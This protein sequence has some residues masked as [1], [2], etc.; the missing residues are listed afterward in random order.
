MF[1]HR[2]FVWFSFDFSVS[3]G[4]SH[5]FRNIFNTM[6]LCWISSYIFSSSSS[7]FS[8][9][10]SIV[11]SSQV[12]HSFSF[13]FVRSLSFS[14]SLSLSLYLFFCEDL[15]TFFF[16]LIQNDNNLLVK[17]LL[18]ILDQILFF[19]SVNWKSKWFFC[20]V[21]SSSLIIDMSIILFSILSVVWTESFILSFPIS[22][23][24]SLSIYMSLLF[25]CI[26]IFNDAFISHLKYNTVYDRSC[27]FF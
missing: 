22:F 16:F 27:D 19:S 11:N 14:L 5:S 10:Y 21:S 25:S 8:I 2:R 9:K 20:Y 26:K 23:Y 24:L 7:C 13:S 15:E 12:F 3:L 18:D 17:I 1:L 4:F 6:Q